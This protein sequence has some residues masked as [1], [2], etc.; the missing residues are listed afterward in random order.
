MPIRKFRDNQTGQIHIVDWNLPRDPTDQELDQEIRKQEQP[1]ASMAPG[2]GMPAA[3]RGFNLPPALNNPAS[4]AKV[5]LGDIQDPSLRH[6]LATGMNELLNTPVTT[7]LGLDEAM[8]G[9]ESRHQTPQSTLDIQQSTPYAQPADPAATGEA[10][11]HITP[12]HILAA[13]SMGSEGII[14]LA[15]NAL[16]G[17]GGASRMVDPQASG[18]EKA[19]GALEAALSLLGGY[20]A[21]RGM[22]GAAEAGPRAGAPP[23]AKPVRTGRFGEKIGESLNPA[24]GDLPLNIPKS[25]QPKLAEDMASAM[26]KPLGN[27]IKGSDQGQLGDIDQAIKEEQMMAASRRARHVRE[28]RDLTLSEQKADA[29]AYQAALNAQRDLEASTGQLADR[30]A[31]LRART[32]L[33]QIDRN[34]EQTGTAAAGRRAATV[35][36]EAKVQDEMGREI[37]ASIDDMGQL[38]RS[39]LNSLDAA[40]LDEQRGAQA[41]RT[42]SGRS[43]A[44]ATLDE[45][46]ADAEW[47]KTQQAEAARKEAETQNR[48]RAGQIVD[49]ADSIGS[50][51]AAAEAAAAEAKAFNLARSTVKNDELRGLAKHVTEEPSPTTPPPVKVAPAASQAP[52][53]P[54][55]AAL[56][57]Q[58]S[59]LGIT[60]EQASRLSPDDLNSLVTGL[61][62]QGETAPPAAVIP[63]MSPASEKVAVKSPVTPASE[64]VTPGLEGAKKTLISIEEAAAAKGVNPKTIRR[65]IKSGSLS[66]SRVGRQWRI[67]PEDMNRM[68]QWGAR[69]VPPVGHDVPGP[70]DMTPGP[71]QLSPGVRTIGTPKPRGKGDIRG[72]NAVVKGDE[73]LSEAMSGLNKSQRAAVYKEFAGRAKNVDP[74]DH[75]SLLDEVV[76]TAREG[77][78]PGQKGSANIESLSGLGGGVVGAAAGGTQGDTPKERILNA[79]LGGAGGAAL[80]VSGARGLTLRRLLKESG[81]VPFV[82]GESP[83]IGK[84][85][86]EFLNGSGAKLPP[87]LNADELISGIDSDLKNVGG[88][89][90]EY[91]KG[92][93]KLI[94]DESGAIATDLPKTLWSSP[95]VRSA[96]GGTIGYN[97]A[98]DDKKL[99]GALLGAVGGGMAAPRSMSGLDRFLPYLGRASYESMLAGPAQISNALGNASTLLTTPF[100]EA[101]RGHIQSAKN[102]VGEGVANPAA[103]RSALDGLRTGYREQRPVKYTGELPL[104][105]S[106]RALNAVDR[107]TKNIMETGGMDPEMVGHYTFT[108]D[109]VTEGIKGLQYLQQRV[110]GINA[111]TPFIRT[112]GKQMELAAAHSPLRHIPTGFGSDGGYNFALRD[113]FPVANPFNTRSEALNPFQYTAMLPGAAAFAAGMGYLGGGTASPTLSAMYGGLAAPYQ[114]GRSIDDYVS[115]GRGGGSDVMRAIA[116]QIPI[117]GDVTKLIED[118]SR[119]PGAFAERFVPPALNAIG[120]RTVR[121]PRGDSAFDIEGYLKERIPGMREELPVKPNFFGQPEQR[122]PWGGLPEPLESRDPMAAELAKMGLLR[123]QQSPSLGGVDLSKQDESQLKSLRGQRMMDI[124]DPILA[125]KAQLGQFPD[126]VSQLPPAQK[127]LVDE[128]TAGRGVPQNQAD[129]VRI[130]Q[131][132][133][134]NMGTDEFKALRLAKIIQQMNG[135]Q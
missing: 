14:P 25:E 79:I 12:G 50:S 17:A 97:T 130:F 38:N 122:T 19:G 61:K 21:T 127:Q 51:D 47:Y 114:I 74:A 99:T 72:I 125:N 42:A 32:G 68:G 4:R 2:S 119:F 43:E 106:G 7:R 105:P 29:E 128:M 120:D 129:I 135:G 5:R 23:V 22:G 9:F 11:R 45:Q 117:L 62:A 80:G 115:K 18:W 94:D 69:T 64:R 10:I 101:S 28:D 111:I 1:P 34:I 96:L 65:A 123:Y 53:T 91:F 20:G 107:A 108:E 27:L 77:K 44:K 16:L 48:I 46:K 49:T 126:V 6:G 56:S 26:D 36:Q 92:Q 60:P 110:P 70:V 55:P 102:L 100:L 83:A 112:M 88:E 85:I 134:I 89:L 98:P 66:A 24:K 95:A 30:A 86:E 109:P 15:S 8:R 121:E 57:K 116:A 87:E 78:L 84:R 76:K 3:S 40:I 63:Q 82:G 52:S 31:N 13:G 73:R 58:L 35:K 132:L 93:Q 67:D 113:T 75:A 41:R 90:D 133:G 124:L 81:D 103:W 54:L 131:Q 59:E 37:G 39:K 104:G 118:P 71:S 33:G